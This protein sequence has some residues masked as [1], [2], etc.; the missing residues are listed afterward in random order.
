MTVGK[1]TATFGGR[2]VQVGFQRLESKLN[3][4]KQHSDFMNHISG[5]NSQ[6]SAGLLRLCPLLKSR[7]KI[8]LELHCDCYFLVSSLLNLF[9]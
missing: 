2:Q 3:M 9:Y 7:L 4:K 5:T 6:K 8:F 1:K